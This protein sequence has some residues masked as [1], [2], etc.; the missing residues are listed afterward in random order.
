MH[1]PPEVEHRF[2]G[3]DFVAAEEEALVTRRSMRFEDEREEGE[4]DGKTSLRR[5]LSLCVSL[6]CFRRRGISL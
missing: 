6:W 5:G 2:D 4:E 1:G 3:V